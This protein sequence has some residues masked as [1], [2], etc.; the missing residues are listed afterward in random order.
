[1]APAGAT[2]AAG[3]DAVAV[4][5]LPQPVTLSKTN[6]TSERT[7]ILEIWDNLNVDILFSWKVLL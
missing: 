1:M 7:D 4:A 6:N 2:A 5:V 3:A